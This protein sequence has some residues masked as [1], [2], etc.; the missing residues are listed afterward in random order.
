MTLLLLRITKN[1]KAEGLPGV[2]SEM[3][4]VAGEADPRITILNCVT[5]SIYISIFFTCF[6]TTFTV[7]FYYIPP[8]L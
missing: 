1:G 7:Y 4:K 3:V 2:L 8:G 6:Y 5:L